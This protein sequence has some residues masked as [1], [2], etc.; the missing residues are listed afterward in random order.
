MD[1]VAPGVY[2][3]L[4]T[5]GLA[6]QLARLDPDLVDR[7]GL[8]EADAHT[9]LTR[10]IA[11][12]ASRALRQVGTGP[13]A[14]ARQVE[15]A[16]RLTQAIVDAAPRAA[17]VEDFADRT[18]ELLMDVHAP[19]VLAF[20]PRARRQR[21]ERPETPLSASALLVNGH[22]QP[23]IGHEVVLELASA[24][25]VDLLCAFIKWEGLRIL[26]AR[27]EEIS[28]RGVPVRVLTTTYI[29][30]TQRRALDALVGLGAEVRIS[31]DTRSTRLH[32]K[33]WL[34]RREHD[35][36]TAY[37]GSS[38]LSRTAMIE[39]L[40][41]NVRLS[42]AEQPHLIDTF[43]ATFDSY[44]AD[45]SF[46]PYDPG[47]DG[48][49]L[50]R[51]LAVERGGSSD[52]PLE[53]AALDVRP[54]GYQQE[55]LDTLSAEREVHDRWRSLVVM[56]TGTGKTVVA[57]LDYARLRE[58]GTVRSLLFV[59]HRAEILRQSRSVFRQVLRRGD[60]GELLVGGDIP[61]QWEVVFASV[62]SL[63]RSPLP[64]PAHFDMVI[65]DEFHHAEA[66]S[67]A[68]LLDHLRPKVLLGLT[69]TPE[70]TDGQ[71]IRHWFD[72]H[73]AVELRLW[74]ALDRGVLA[75]FQY[76]GIHDDVA[77]GQLAWKRGAYDQRE[78]SNLYTGNDHRLRL[79]LQAVR[80]TVAD[81]GRMRALG[82]CV[83]IAHAEFMARRFTE[84]G[85]PS[86]AITSQTSDVERAGALAALA[87][88]KVLVLFTVD[89]FNE[90]IDLPAIDTVLFLRPTESATVFLQQLG[91]GL[92]LS[93]DKACLTVLD[94][95][96]AQ[97]A[98]FRFDRR[99]RALT[100]AARGELVHQ[101]EQDFPTLPSGCHIQ[102]DRVA[103]QV[104]LDNVRA[105]LR[106]GRPELAAELRALGDASLGEFLDRTGVDLEDLYRRKTWGGWTGL[107]RAAGL[108]KAADASGD[109]DE[110]DGPD[111]AAVGSAIGRS[112]HVDDPVRLDRLAATLADPT[113][114]PAD[115]LQRM[116]DAGVWRVDAEPLP[117]QDRHLSG[118]RRRELAELVG[119]LRERIH[120]VTL[121]ASVG[122]RAPLRVH[123]RYSRNEAA[124][125]FGIADPSQLREGVK[126]FPEDQAD[127]F[128]VTLHKTE[129]HY[130]P[131][132]MYAD[133]A[134]SPSVFQWE[135]QSTTRADSPTGQRYV[136][137]RER[138][139][140]VHLFL[141][142]TKTADGDLGAPPYLYAGTM[143]YVAHTGDRPMRITWHLD[144]PLPADVFHAAAVAAG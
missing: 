66:D 23:R 6:G 27:L 136:H 130:S 138:G 143:T 7:A 58:A 18:A 37:V 32:A 15:L 77:L 119:V 100:G 123:A 72:G 50:D 45:P 5:R 93:P 126:W 142:E 53:I 95:V 90:G 4:V 108:D 133:R 39:G 10:H 79:V 85:I 46:E 12:L 57:A 111:D 52:Q 137:H 49:R 74:E 63:A 99:Y 17:T 87:D 140:T 13:D 64:D 1:E 36:T 62:Q 131:T 31:Y 116:V 9:V 29:G 109:R 101:I 83:S 67:Y 65:V 25:G 35:L 76:F 48:D 89:L 61:Q 104:V 3:H 73:T 56:A 97:H 70:R 78:L 81:P 44:W 128:F 30:A 71:D 28:A 134:I 75:P 107:R 127:V 69:A 125:A 92:R 21:V 38:N 118:P 103:K 144:H 115:R 82:F 20:R 8:D 51:A 96:G 102:L 68:R 113:G 121:P 120:R 117:P 34:F 33:A 106:V 2:E 105:S 88:R 91:R 16:N 84:A 40:E 19:G 24:I 47:R 132:T 11:G 124:L 135:S 22:G 129:T 122:V 60:L 55:V 94:F 14:L 80:D 141:R 41:W 54:Y 139:S 42:A 59:A 26:L 112:L 114:Q 86:L 110:Q 43:T 98:K